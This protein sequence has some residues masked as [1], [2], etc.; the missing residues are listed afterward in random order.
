LFPSLREKTS[1]VPDIQLE[2]ENF[3]G[4]DGD[5]HTIFDFGKNSMPQEE[6]V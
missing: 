1:P 2:N 5:R 6:V 3:S 4:P